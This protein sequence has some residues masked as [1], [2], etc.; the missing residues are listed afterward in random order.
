MKFC[1]PRAPEF[2]LQPPKKMM[3]GPLMFAVWPYRGRGG[4]PET[5]TRAHS[6]FYVSRILISFK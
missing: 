3:S 1:S 5:L 4:V 2:M 6:Y